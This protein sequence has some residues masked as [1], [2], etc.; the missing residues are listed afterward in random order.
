MNPDDIIHF[1]PLARV[2]ATSGTPEEFQRLVGNLLDS[3][4]DGCRS[5]QEHA[6]RLDESMLKD[7]LAELITQLCAVDDGGRPKDRLARAMHILGMSIA[8]FY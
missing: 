7:S 2:E 3:I 1:H 8:D 4:F 5:T 6:E